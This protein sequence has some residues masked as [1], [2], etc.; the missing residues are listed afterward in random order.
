MKYL[1]TF[2]LAFFFLDAICQDN[3]SDTLLYKEGRQSFDKFLNREINKPEYL[4]DLTH[5][6]YVNVNMTIGID[7]KIKRIDFFSVDD[8][9]FLQI[10][11]NI[12]MQTDGRW[13]NSSNED[14]ILN[15]YFE[16][17]YAVKF[18][19]KEAP[20]KCYSDIYENGK[21]KKITRFGKFAMIGYPPVH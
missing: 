5:N 20:I 7:G 1:L 17:R 15:I 11:S 16:F 18:V 21:P 10:L 14:Q 8:S 4:R 19:E 9:L 12:L 6:I 3:Q 13:I 2:L